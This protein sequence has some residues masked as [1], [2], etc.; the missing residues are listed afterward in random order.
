MGI[1]PKYVGTFWGVFEW[2]NC[3]QTHYQF[4]MCES[5]R[6]ENSETC[7]SVKWKIIS[8]ERGVG[9]MVEDW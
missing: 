6:D 5:H 2:G 9:R 1:L 7:K 8:V 4:S 3:L